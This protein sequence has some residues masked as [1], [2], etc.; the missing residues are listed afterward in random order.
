MAV[1]KD[2]RTGKGGSR[3][4]GPLDA[5]PDIATDKIPHSLY[6]LNKAF[7]Y[8]FRQRSILRYLCQ[9]I[10]MRGITNH[11]LDKSAFLGNLK[12]QPAEWTE[13][14]SSVDFGVTEKL[15]GITDKGRRK[16]NGVTDGAPEKAGYLSDNA[17]RAVH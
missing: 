7:R 11:Y 17:Y 6:R 12:R 13:L 2:E 5:A 14:R 15:N 1:D 3:G 9:R 4:G 8:V 16:L 10:Y